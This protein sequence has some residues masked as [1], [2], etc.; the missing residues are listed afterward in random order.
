MRFLTLFNFARGVGHALYHMPGNLYQ[1]GKKAGETFD[2]SADCYQSSPLVAARIALHDA[3]SQFF[4][5]LITR[6]YKSYI[7]VNP[8]ENT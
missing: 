1:A 4:K 8:Q 2:T 5:S 6:S 7:E 3:Q